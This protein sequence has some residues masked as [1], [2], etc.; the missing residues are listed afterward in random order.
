MTL[1]NDLAPRLL[2]T[3]ERCV[4]RITAMR[5]QLNAHDILAT[6]VDGDTTKRIDLVAEEFLISFVDSL[7]LGINIVTEESGAVTLCDQPKYLMFLDPI[8]GT[9]MFLR[10]VPLSNIALSIIDLATSTQVLSIVYDIAL[11]KAYVADGGTGYILCNG[12]KQPLSVSDNQDISKAFVSSY[13]VS[14]NRIYMLAQQDRLLQ[15]VTKFFN[16]AGPLEIARVAEGKMDAHIEFA[17]GLK[18]IDYLPGI[19]LCQLA[20]AIVTDLDGNPLTMPSDL[21]H[22]QKFVAS[23]N[24]ALHE[25]LLDLLR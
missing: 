16:Y 12:V 23:A 10:H 5:D 22:R 20:G 7:K 18:S 1:P 8:D 2:Q 17:K 3:I 11:N 4:E 14:P 6:K 24:P 21:Y 25:K 9:D 19:H 15:N 13:F